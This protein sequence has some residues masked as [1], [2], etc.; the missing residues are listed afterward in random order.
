MGD[1]RER[2]ARAGPAPSDRG[3][4]ADLQLRRGPP[5]RASDARTAGEMPIVCFILCFLFFLFSVFYFCFSLFLIFNVLYYV[6]IKIL[7]FRCFK[8]SKPF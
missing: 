3:V 6:Y 1:V 8:F 7:Y 4:H 2:H 5:A